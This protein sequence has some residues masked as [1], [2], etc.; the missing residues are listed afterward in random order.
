[1]T[2]T[3]LDNEAAVREFLAALGPD[4]AGVRAAIDRHMTP[5]VLYTNPG[6]PPCHGREAVVG[7]YEEFAR[8][9]GF[10]QVDIEM[11]HV[12]AAGDLVMTERV[13]RAL[14][15]SGELIGG[16]ATPAMG[17]FEMRD[18]RIAVWR[19]YYDPSPLLAHFASLG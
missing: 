2:V 8:I 3:G 4:M 1:M 11:L 6:L 10:A 17:T 16:E 14:T 12:L 5:D 19:D 9:A 7:L 18:G 13:D 15:A